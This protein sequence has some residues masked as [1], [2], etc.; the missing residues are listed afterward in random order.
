MLLLEKLT[1]RS[2]LPPSKKFCRLSAA[3]GKSMCYCFCRFVSKTTSGLA[4]VL[5][6]FSPKEQIAEEV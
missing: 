4:R 1:K 2:G 5:A 3:P 6:L